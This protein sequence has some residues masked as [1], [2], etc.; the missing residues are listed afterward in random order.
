LVCTPM[1]MDRLSGAPS[2]A[3]GRRFDRLFPVRLA[4]EVLAY[5]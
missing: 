1:V 5:G 3:D 2:G 4:A